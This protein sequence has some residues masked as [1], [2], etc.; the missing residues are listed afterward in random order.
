L[1]QAEFLRH[2]VTALRSAG[3]PYA[4]TGSQASIMY[5]EMRFTNDI[6]VVAA[7]DDRSLQTFLVHFPPDDFYVSDQAA[8]S[9]VRSGG[10]FKII[11]PTS[12]QKVDVIVPANEFDKSLLRRARQM[13]ISGDLAASIIS[14][15]DLILKKMEFYREGGSDKHLRDIAGMLV[16]SGEIID[17]ADIERRAREMGLL[18]VWQAVLERVAEQ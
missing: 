6:D 1:D 18:D 8:Q 15:E 2:V 11:H 3:V 10:Q 12:A 5:G 16:I 14:P 13:D 7:L 4:I 9:A 17:R